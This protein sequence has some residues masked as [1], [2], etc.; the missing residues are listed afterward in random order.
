MESL[1]QSTSGREKLTNKHF[2]NGWYASVVEQT[3]ILCQMLAHDKEMLPALKYNPET[4]KNDLGWVE[5]TREDIRQVYKV[6]LSFTEKM[7]NQLAEMTRNA[8]IYDRAIKN[9]NVNRKEAFALLIGN[10]KQYRQLTE[11]VNPQENI[12][13][14]QAVA[15]KEP[16]SGPEGAAAPPEMPMTGGAGMAAGGLPV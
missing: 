4:G 5:I 14:M 16:G 13:A 12:A 15:G 9:E 10:T 2:E 1:R 6:Q 7:A 3:L 11:G 8:M